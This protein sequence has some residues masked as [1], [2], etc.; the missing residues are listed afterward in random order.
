M[1]LHRPLSRIAALG[2]GVLLLATGVA[3]AEI[4]SDGALPDDV[5]P[6]TRVAGDDRYATAALTALQAAPDGADTV[7]IARGDAFPDGLAAAYL[8][9]ATDAPILLAAP[10]RL[11]FPTQEAME[12]LGATQAIIVGG[13][14][15]I[16]E[17]V[18]A[19]LKER[20]GDDNVGRIAGSDRFQTAA[21]LFN[22]TGVVGRI[23][24]LSEETDDRL[25]TAIVASGRN[26]PDALAA[27]PLAHAARLPILLTEPDSLPDITRIVLESGIQQVIVAGGPTTIAPSV[28]ASIQDIDGIRVVRRVSG[29]DRTATAAQLAALTRDQLGWPATHAAVALGTDFP[30]ALS[31]APAAT[32]WR[33]PVLLTR[34]STE[35]GA[36]T[37]AALQADCDTLTDL[38]VAGGETAITTAA[39][40][41]LELATSCADL[42]TALTA[43]AVVGGGDAGASGTAWLWTESLCYAVRAQD[44]SS[45][46]IAAHVHAAS[47][48]EDG[49]VAATL[50]VPSPTTGD[51][52]AVG[53]LTD[54]DVNDGTRGDLRSA[55][56]EDPSAFH[57]DVHSEDHPDGAVRG[58]LG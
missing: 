49:Q 35:A 37:F 27:G 13:P 38:T 10:N 7:V 52:L 1:K 47:A 3:S 22:E 34:S 45:P 41:A 31:L 23:G 54:D 40:R 21:L 4:A 25:T 56:T 26:F 18:E 57:V 12:E 6:A 55:I 58:Q 17:D 53:C 24:D 28:L 30:D 29:A 19:L 39:E 33:A 15:A 43:E 32:T 20:L 2:T 44:L 16:N 42:T 36:A 5:Q 46:A 14:A 50:D 48:G 51:G 8:S 11:P 9:G